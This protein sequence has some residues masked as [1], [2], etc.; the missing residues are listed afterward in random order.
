V[1]FVLQNAQIGSRYAILRQS[2]NEVLASGTI[3]SDPQ[4]I[5]VSWFGP[6]GDNT[7][8]VKLR[9]GSSSQKYQPFTTVASVTPTGFIQ[10]SPGT[11][12]FV[13][14]IPDSIA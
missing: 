1:G 3:S 5:Q 4:T 9:K 11:S 13:V 2:N 7:V 12:V 14:Q 8:L 10:I 6:I